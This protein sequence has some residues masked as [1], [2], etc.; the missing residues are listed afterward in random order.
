MESPS[1][2][3]LIVVGRAAFPRDPVPSG[4]VALATATAATTEVSVSGGPPPLRPSRWAGW[5]A[6]WN[7]PNWWGQVEQLTDT[8]WACMDLNASV[9]AAMPP[10]LV[11]AVP[12]LNADWINN[13]DPD[14]YDSWGE[15]TKQLVWDFQLGEVYV[16]PTAF[17]ATGWPAR[18]HVVSPWR[19]SVDIDEATGMRR[20]RIGDVDVSDRILPIRYQSRVEDPRGHGPLEAGRDRLVAANALARY[21]TDLAASGGLPYALLLHP[22]RLTDEQSS[23]LQWE[24]VSKRTASMGLPGVL[25]GGIDLKVL[26]YDPEKMAYVDLARFNEARIAVLLG[27]PPPLVG[28][29]SGQDSLTYNTAVMIREQHWQGGLK[30]KVDR[31]MRALSQW[32]LPRGTTV[33][34]NRDEYIRPDQLERART[35]E[36]YLRNEVV[37][38][39]E[40][41]EGERFS[42]AASTETTTSGVLQ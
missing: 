22:Q 40:V 13:P 26:S 35:W 25:S 31:L 30:P 8:A 28:L 18:F 1:P 10:Y 12:S 24:W 37:S 17:Y 9:I 42:L 21:A 23:S 11:N 7:L 29:P 33:E 20:Y 5:P 19:V 41:R 6:D 36:I 15:F 38:V 2:S 16:M 14:V 3:G 39:D 32:A 34:V 27:V 4:D